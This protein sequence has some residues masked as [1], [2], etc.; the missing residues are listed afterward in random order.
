VAFCH[1]FSPVFYNHDIEPGAA[2][3][4]FIKKWSLVAE[5]F[6]PVMHANADMARLQRQIEHL[7]AKLEKT[8][9][10]VVNDPST[11]RKPVQFDD[12]KEAQMQSS[13]S[14]AIVGV[15]HGGSPTPIK[16]R[17][18]QRQRSRSSGP[19]PQESRGRQLDRQPNEQRKDTSRPRNNNNNQESSG[20][21]QNGQYERQRRDSY[22]GQSRNFNR[23]GL[24]RKGMQPSFFRGERVLL[25]VE[26]DLVGN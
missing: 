1:S 21:G 10:R 8:Q 15:N 18:D 26:I 5:S 14:N 11:S 25:G 6:L 17:G 24:R 16:N 9:M 2:G 22:V 20:G 13:C 12:N 19:T 23:G 7:S 4:A 3:L